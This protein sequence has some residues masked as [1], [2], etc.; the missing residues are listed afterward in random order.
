MPHITTVEH[1]IAELRKHK[2]P[3]LSESGATSPILDESFKKGSEKDNASHGAS[4]DLDTLL[5]Q[6]KIPGAGDGLGKVGPP[7]FD[8]ASAIES[9]VN[10]NYPTPPTQNRADVK[11]DLKSNYQKIIP[12]TES[13]AGRPE[14]IDSTPGF[15]SSKSGNSS[16]PPKQEATESEDLL[17]N[18]GAHQ[19]GFNSSLPYSKTSPSMCSGVENLQNMLFGSASQTTP[20]NSNSTDVDHGTDMKKF[21]SELYMLKEFSHENIVVV[22]GYALDNN[23]LCLVYQ[24]L[25]NGSL[26][27]RLQLKKGTPPLKWE[28]RLNIV[29]GAC[30][31][32][33][34]L[35]TFRNKALIHGDIKSANILL[36]QN[37]EAKIADLGQA[38]YATGASKDTKGYTHVSVVQ[39]GT[40]VFGTKAYHAP[41]VFLEVCSGLRAYDPNRGMEPFLVRIFTDLEEDQWLTFQDKH[42]DTVPETSFT[43][44]LTIANKCVQESKAKR[45]T[46]KSLLK[47]VQE[48]YNSWKLSTGNPESAKSGPYQFDYQNIEELRRK[49]S[50]SMLSENTLASINSSLPGSRI[51]AAQE[52]ILQQNS[53][54]V[55]NQFQGMQAMTQQSIK[56]LPSQTDE[57]YSS[58]SGQGTTQQL[59]QSHPYQ[60]L[61]QNQVEQNWPQVSARQLYQG[62]EQDKHLPTVNSIPPPAKLSSM[63]SELSNSS[64]EVMYGDSLAI[65]LQ[66]V[67]DQFAAQKE[68]LR[69][70]GVEDLESDKLLSQQMED[71]KQQWLAENSDSEKNK[72]H[73]QI[74]QTSAPPA[75]ND[76][77]PKADPKKLL[78]LYMFDQQ[79]FPASGDSSE[80]SD[81]GPTV[82]P[83]DPRKLAYMQ[84]FDASSFTRTSE[85]GNTR[86]TTAVSQSEQKHHLP[87]SNN[88]PQSFSNYS[89]PHHYS[90]LPHGS[91]YSG[92]P[93]TCQDFYT[94]LTASNGGQVNTPNPEMTHQVMSCQGKH[95]SYMVGEHGTN[96]FLSPAQTADSLSQQAASAV[97]ND[98]ADH[99]PSS[100]YRHFLQQD[101]QQIIGKRQK[102]T[103]LDDLMAEI[104]SEDSLDV[105]VDFS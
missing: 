53:A 12:W 2:Q 8:S 6:V 101:N 81:P 103:E 14:P 23:E 56:S 22:Y 52:Q 3:P 75:E 76:Y 34:F 33:S 31:G 84:Q 79:N 26:E 17:P 90:P 19:S 40:K 77:F 73:Q 78:E 29:L 91:P 42:L 74:G 27:D 70:Q 13:V 98:P 72:L 30:K 51:A 20:G 21:L 92:V 45:P 64:L 9:A 62:K 87:F 102:K 32:L 47:S 36:D 94:V 63:P 99:L 69:Q 10:Y 18:S 67:V 46:T 15:P 80:Q 85:T 24:H 86:T 93:S 97:R 44:I 71:I 89:S 38:A 95:L 54:H 48:C 50:Q 105:E 39:A 5:R 88:S 65:R 58:M 60:Q 4:P 104:M 43:S 100:T 68:Q 59:S 61:Q 37:W 1:G 83:C 82:F 7:S 96:T 55:V 25:I 41:E 35:H 11:P 16:V 28:R 57:I 49:L 66:K